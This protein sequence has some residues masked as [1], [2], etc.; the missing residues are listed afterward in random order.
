MRHLVRPTP[1]ILQPLYYIE[2]ARRDIN[3]PASSGTEELA[4]IRR[5]LMQLRAA[6]AL[7]DSN[8]RKRQIEQAASSERSALHLPRLRQ[9]WRRARARLEHHLF[10]N[11]GQFQRLGLEPQLPTA[12]GS[13]SP[14]AAAGGFGPVASPNNTMRRRHE[15]AFL[16]KYEWNAGDMA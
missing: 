3:K 2:Q 11:C 4:L 10:A 6:Q 12:P 8:E 9:N 1:E 15:D 16:S 7:L 5:V 14:R 13:P